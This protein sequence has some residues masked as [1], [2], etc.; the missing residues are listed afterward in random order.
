MRQC[1]PSPHPRFQKVIR[2][3]RS[4]L[5]PLLPDP[6]PVVQGRSQACPI[7]VLVQAMRLILFL[8]VVCP[9]WKAYGHFMKAS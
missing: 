7:C 9:F 8:P 5:L 4:H 6:A 3:R 1:S 2:A